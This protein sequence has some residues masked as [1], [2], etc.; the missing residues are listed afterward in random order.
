MQK[1]SNI[2]EGDEVFFDTS[3]CL[4]LEGSSVGKAAWMCADFDFDLDYDVWLKE[5][6]SVNE[7]RD[8]FL[9]TMG[10]VEC[11][12]ATK[13]EATGFDSTAVALDDGVDDNLLLSE[14][15]KSNS[16][17]N[18]SIDYSD[19]DWLD[20]IVI[21]TEGETM[22]EHLVAA[23][24]CEMKQ[25]RANLGEIRTFGNK[26][27]VTNWWRNFSRRMKKGG[28]A[29]SVCKGLEKG[30]KMARMRV[31]QN[32]KK[33]VEC[34]GVYAGQEVKAHNGLIWT[35][36]FSPDG[37]YLATGGEDGIVCI[38][39][40]SMVD[41]S[42]DRDKCAFGSLDKSNCQKK[43]CDASIVIPEKIFRIEE[44]PLQKLY[45]HCSDVLDLAWSTSN[46]KP[47]AID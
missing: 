25:V 26:K 39:R 5:P 24:K 8:S 34:T 47:L 22:N 45:G 13:T 32:R 27:K 15:R 21:D 16:E 2:G 4:M 28:G 44:E 17:A 41:A 33:C 7:R 46:V 19:R 18:C 29:S 6:R 1:M 40:I 38:W 14:R 37:Q 11:S 10:F 31:E 3:D 43:S 12:I 36:K 9:S 30:G 20:N 35:M 42:C 23:E